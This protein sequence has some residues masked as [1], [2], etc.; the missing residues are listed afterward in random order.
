MGCFTS[1]HKNLS[2][3]ETPQQTVSTSLCVETPP[4]QQ[5]VSAS[6]CIETPPSQQ[7]V[8]SPLLTKAPQQQTEVNDTAIKLLNEYLLSRKMIE[9]FS[10]KGDYKAYVARVI[11]GDTI[12]ANFRFRGEISSFHVR[13]YGLDTP[14][15]HPKKKGLTPE[16]IKSIKNDA[17]CAKRVLEL[18]I[19]HEFVLLIVNDERDKY[20][21]VLAKVIIRG[22]D[23]AKYIIECG[24]GVAYYGKK[25]TLKG[26]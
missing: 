21:R 1:R 13:I 10:F 3:T 15:L 19:L 12:V 14:E 18:E 25:K 16:E 5:T 6:L 7:T 17:I 22:T 9:P 11:D 4:P 2:R 20:G 8:N 26:N 24:Y 23:I